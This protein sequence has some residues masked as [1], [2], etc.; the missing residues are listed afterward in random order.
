MRKNAI[1]TFTAPTA[2]RMGGQ[3]GAEQSLETGEHA[4]GLPTLTIDPARKPA[5]H[6]TTITTADAAWAAAGVHRDDR[7]S[8]AQLLPAEPMVFF[9]VITPVAQQAVNA[10]VLDRL[11]DCG[12]KVW[13]VVTGSGTDPGCPDEMRIVVADD[14]QLGPRAVLLHTAAAVQEVPADVVT[15]HAGGINARL[16]PGLQQ[17][18]GLGDTENG[19]EQLVKSPFFRSRCS[20]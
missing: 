7:G 6:L 19:I 3:V 9:G 8:D 2:G 18:S 1:Q 4:F 14:G 15:A 17:A 11:G 16:R 5:L 12:P 13:G 10:K 20:A